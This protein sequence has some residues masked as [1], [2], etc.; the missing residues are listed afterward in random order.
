[1]KMYPIPYGDILFR[2]FRSD[3]N[4]ANSETV[5]FGMHP[6]SCCSFSFT[7]CCYSCIPLFPL[8]I[9]PPF[10]SNTIIG[11]DIKVESGS[12]YQETCLY[13]GH[14]ALTITYTLPL[15]L[16][17]SLSLPSF[18][19]FLSLSFLLYFSFYSWFFL[20]SL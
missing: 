20:F 6:P 2:Y 19:S 9:F 18:L 14:F 1:M 17:S 3:N 16:L 7:S 13:I 5:S 15:F 12:K 4:M 8:F 11:E 10:F